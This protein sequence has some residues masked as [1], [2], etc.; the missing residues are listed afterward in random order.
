MFF[1][2]LRRLATIA[3]AGGA[4]GASDNALA[5]YYTLRESVAFKICD[6]HWLCAHEVVKIGKKMPP[7]YFESDED[8]KKL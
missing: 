8:D 5:C 2:T 6:K 4:S 1:S 7:P 3:A